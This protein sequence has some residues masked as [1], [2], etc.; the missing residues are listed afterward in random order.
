MKTVFIFLKKYFAILNAIILKVSR[1]HTGLSH[2]RERKFKYN[3]PDSSNPIFE[4]STGVK[5]CLKF[6][7]HCPPFQNEGRIL[8]S[9]LKNSESKVLD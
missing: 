7:L 8:L 1:L 5:S 9:T 4:C 3:F 2:L 6:F